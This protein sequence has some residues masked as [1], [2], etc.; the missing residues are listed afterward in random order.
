M[1]CPSSAALRAIGFSWMKPFY[2]CH[3]R[4]RASPGR[5]AYRDRVSSKE[6]HGVH[7]PY[8]PHIPRAITAHPHFGRSEVK[9]LFHVG[10]GSVWHTRYRERFVVASVGN[11]RG[12]P[13]IWSGV[14]RL[15][16]DHMPQASHQLAPDC[17]HRLV[18]HPSPATRVDSNNQITRVFRNSAPN[19][20]GYVDVWTPAP[21]TS[22]SHLRQLSPLHS[23]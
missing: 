8:C 12:F 19:S 2:Y 16:S 6:K 15:A 23:R 17:D 7:S 5:G 21:G 14:K 3:Q 22:A 9:T 13:R 1:L 11:T 20:A 4:T 10:C 18:L